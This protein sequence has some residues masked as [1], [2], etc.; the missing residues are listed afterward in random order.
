MI[1][2]KIKVDSNIKTIDEFISNFKNE[3]IINES[4]K[5]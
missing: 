2:E 3:G 4:L 1:C 5:N